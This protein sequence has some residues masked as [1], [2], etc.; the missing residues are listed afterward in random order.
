MSFNT[1]FFIQI[2]DLDFTLW[3]TKIKTEHFCLLNGKY[4]KS[5]NYTKNTT[6]YIFYSIFFF[7]F[8]C[9]SDSN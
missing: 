3:H 4:K 5:F 7:Q 1:L 6:K 9:V 8:L 2:L